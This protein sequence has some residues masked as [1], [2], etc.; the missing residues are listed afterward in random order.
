MGN[1]G[2]YGM[3]ALQNQKRE[4]LATELTLFRTGERG[5]DVYRVMREPAKKLTDAEIAALAAY[6]G[7]NQ[8]ASK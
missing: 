8:A 7:S 6:Y 5:N 3:P 1:P 4:E 2:F